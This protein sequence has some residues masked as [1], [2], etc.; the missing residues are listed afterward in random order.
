MNS[1]LARR[2]RRSTIRKD[3]VGAG[4]MNQR[5]GS[6]RAANHCPV[7]RGWAQPDDG[8]SGRVSLPRGDLLPIKRE[9]AE[10]SSDDGLRGQRLSERFYVAVTGQF[11]G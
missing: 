2:R 5:A 1:A 7:V 9:A 10:V 6:R 4:T 11:A 3:V 8:R